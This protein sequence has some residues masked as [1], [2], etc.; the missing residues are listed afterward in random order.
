MRRG[1]LPGQ[2]RDRER[3]EASCPWKETVFRS[4]PRPSGRGSRGTL[5]RPGRGAAH[6]IEESLPAL[7]LLQGLPMLDQERGAIRAAVEG[8]PREG[9]PGR[10][11]GPVED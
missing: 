8:I 1:D 5:V 10:E 2:P 3:W 4:I 9:G 7:G 11:R 6:E